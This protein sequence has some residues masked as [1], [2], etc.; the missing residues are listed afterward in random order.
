MMLPTS[1]AGLGANSAHSPS[2]EKAESVGGAAGEAGDGDVVGGCGRCG[3]KLPRAL[4]EVSRGAEVCAGGGGE[5]ADRAGGPGAAGWD[6]G[7]D[8]GNPAPGI[9]SEV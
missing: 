8:G 9:G 3:R 5:A 7:R 2:R 6:R 1:S 4:R